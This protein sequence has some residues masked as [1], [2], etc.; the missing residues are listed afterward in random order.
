MLLI[1]LIRCL[2]FCP[3]FFGYVGKRFDKK[4]K[5]NFKIYDVFYSEAN[6]CGNNT[7]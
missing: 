1:L 3:A 4:A 6:N 7:S 5:F 2:N